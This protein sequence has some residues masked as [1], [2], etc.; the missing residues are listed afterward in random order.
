MEEFKWT[1]KFNTGITSID[2][3]HRELFR[4]IDKLAL[5]IYTGESKR[6]L[7][8]SLNF[9]EEYIENHFL[10]EENLMELNYYNDFDKHARQHKQFRILFENF[11]DDF[12]Q[13]GGDSYLAI[14]LEK[15][16]RKWWEYHILNIDMMYVPY[17]KK[18]V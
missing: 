13:R 10:D 4:E 7:K 12:A 17:I 3:Q 15:E 11:K 16:I 9:L 1:E 8:G 2:R 6:H 14:R 5:A 18:T